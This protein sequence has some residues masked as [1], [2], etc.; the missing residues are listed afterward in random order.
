MPLLAAWLSRCKKSFRLSK[1]FVFLQTEI[2][3][4]K[5][6]FLLL[7]D[8]NTWKDAGVVDRGGLENR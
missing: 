2:G 4:W 7:T 5:S 1:K 3:E 6:A 8:W